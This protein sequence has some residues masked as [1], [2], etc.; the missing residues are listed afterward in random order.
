MARPSTPQ[1]GGLPGPALDSRHNVAFGRLEASI[2]SAQKQPWTV[3][4]T[5]SS[6]ALFLYNIRGNGIVF[7]PFSGCIDDCHSF[8]DNLQRPETRHKEAAN[9]VENNTLWR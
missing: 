5:R 1:P 7:G 4:G 9:P 8:W 2:F 6:S 3:S